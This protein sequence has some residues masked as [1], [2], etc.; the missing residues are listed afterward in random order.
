MFC[1]SEKKITMN[2]TNLHFDVVVVGLGKT[3]LSCVRYLS[4]QGLNIA[5]TDSRLEPPELTSFD[6]ELVL[7]QRTS[8]GL[9]KKHY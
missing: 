5:V 7:Y 6:N 2:E 8:V 9:V 1:I 4:K 3:G